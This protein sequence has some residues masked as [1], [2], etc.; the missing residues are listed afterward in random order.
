M[1]SIV[2]FGEAC[3]TLFQIKPD[4]KV[5][6]TLILIELATSKDPVT[7]KELEQLTGQNSGSVSRNMKILGDKM[8]KNTEGGWTNVGLG[9]VIGRPNPYAPKEY[10]AEL[11]GKGKNLIAKIEGI[12]EG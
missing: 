5:Q 8:V 11:S 6:Q 3:R 7:F 4:I 10:V 2:K 12:L 9:L 1:R